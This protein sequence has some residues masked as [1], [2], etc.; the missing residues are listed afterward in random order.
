MASLLSF[1]AV[2]TASTQTKPASTKETGFLVVFGLHGVCWAKNPVS[3][4]PCVQDYKSL[5]FPLDLSPFLAIFLIGDLLFAVLT[6]SPVVLVPF[7][8]VLVP[9][10]AA[11]VPFVLTTPHKTKTSVRRDDKF[12]I[13][14]MQFQNGSP[15][16]DLP[17]PPLIQYS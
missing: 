7:V 10:V 8:V 17:N 2:E 12:L 3:D 13:L 14:P 6:L 1:S 4:Y 5:K 11:L 15:N 9:F 16:A